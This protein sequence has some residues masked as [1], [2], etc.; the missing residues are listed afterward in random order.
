MDDTVDELTIFL[1]RAR[2][3]LS[4]HLP[5]AMADDIADL[6]GDYAALIGGRAT[7]MVSSIARPLMERQMELEARL[8]RLE[9]RERGSE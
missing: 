4:R 7:G 3:V 2:I 9:Q 6:L 1:A 8:D 5:A